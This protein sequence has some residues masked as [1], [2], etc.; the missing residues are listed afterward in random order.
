MES[1]DV[2]TARRLLALPA[3]ALT[4]A[5]LATGCSTL[6]A[7]TGGGAAAPVRDESGAIAESNASTDV[8]AIRVGDCMLDSGT[9]DTE[10][11][12]TPTV[13][14]SEAHDLEAYHAQDIDADEFPGVEA[15]QTEA[16]Q[17]CYDAFAPFVGI[18]YEES[19]LGFNYYVPTAGSWD[20]GDREIL[21]LIGDP[22][23]QVTGTLAG[24]AR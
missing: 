10:V 8:F 20:A 17:V 7:F 15:A 21:C 14:C 6:N 2:N 1:V 13:P 19:V 9:A 18:S 3:A 24:A 22:Q 4:V 11:T 23:G 12:E 16:E 5:L